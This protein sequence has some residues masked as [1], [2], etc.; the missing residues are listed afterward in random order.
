MTTNAVGHSNNSNGAPQSRHD[1]Y[2]FYFQIEAIR[3]QGVH[4]VGA[5]PGDATGVQ[6]LTDG[7]AHF[8]AGQ[9]GAHDPEE[10]F[11]TVE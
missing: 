7:M 9:A 10:E 5:L 3:L 4:L 2:S 1:L 8:V 11:V 6:A